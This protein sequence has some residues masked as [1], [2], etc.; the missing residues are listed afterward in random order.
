METLDEVLVENS[1]RFMDQ[2]KQSG[3]P[4]YIWHNTTRMHVFTYLQQKYQAKMNYE[5]NYGL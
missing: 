4:I 1:K 2:A 5:S 3:K